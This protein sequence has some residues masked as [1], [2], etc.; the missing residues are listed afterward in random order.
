MFL[1]RKPGWGRMRPHP[2]QG[3]RAGG[4]GL[5]GGAGGGEKHGM[6]KSRGRGRQ[7]A[8]QAGHGRGGLTPGLL[9]PAAKGK[10]VPSPGNPARGRGSAL[11]A[12]L[13]LRVPWCQLGG[14]RL[15]QSS[16]SSPQPSLDSRPS[17]T[18]SWHPNRPDGRGWGTELSAQRARQGPVL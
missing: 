13:S 6:G 1:R 2:P 17:R 10:V 18:A 7:D 14:D 3:R 4:L 12:L 8:P 9:A 5:G 15:L 16:T 11:S